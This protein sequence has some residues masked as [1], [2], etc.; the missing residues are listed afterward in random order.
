MSQPHLH[1]MLIERPELA[2][3]DGAMTAL[4]SSAAARTGVAGSPWNV[5]RAL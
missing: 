5:R 3:P 4:A 1:G 2:I